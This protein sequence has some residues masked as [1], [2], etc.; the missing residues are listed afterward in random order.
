MADAHPEALAVA[1]VVLPRTS[2]EDG[3]VRFLEELLETDRGP[4]IAPR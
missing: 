4:A 1:D 3:A 2:E